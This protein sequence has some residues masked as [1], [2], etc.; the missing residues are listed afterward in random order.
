[1]RLPRTGCPFRIDE[2]TRY[3]SIRVAAKRPTATLKKMQKIFARACHSLHVQKTVSH[4]SGLWGR[5][6][7]LKKKCFV[8]NVSICV[9]TEFCW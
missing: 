6:T 1:M 9:P 3:K 2:R 7:Q 4:M 8:Q 5:V